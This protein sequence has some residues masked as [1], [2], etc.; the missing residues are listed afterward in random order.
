MNKT[1]GMCLI[2]RNNKKKKMCDLDENSNHATIVEKRMHPRAL[3]CSSE[4]KCFDL[5]Q[6][7][8]IYVFLLILIS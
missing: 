1:K 4:S 5:N 2:D 6:Y 8:S 7:K 3:Y